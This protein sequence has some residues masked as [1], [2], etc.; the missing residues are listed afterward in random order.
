MKRTSLTMKIASAAVF[1]AVACY[2]AFSL[3]NALSDP[4]R[5]TLAV[6]M[7]AR[8]SFR[9]SGVIARSE[10]V[11]LSPGGA[12]N[13]LAGTGEKIAAGGAIAE[14][15][16]DASAL[17]LLREAEELEGRIAT[18]EGILASGGQP[19]K[20]SLERDIRE[21]VF[22][23]VLD[24]RSG[25]L[26]D[27]AGRL[28]SLEAKML[29]TTGGGDELREKLASLRQRRIAL[30]A[31]PGSLTKVLSPAS[32]VFCPVTDGY[33]DLTPAALKAM[34]AEALAQLI[35]GSRSAPS[36]AVGRVA[37][38]PRW[39]FATVL[40]YE[41]AAKLKSGGYAEMIFGKYL[42]T[43]IE[44]YV[45]SVGLVSG[46]KC[47]VV[48]SSNKNLADVLEARKQTVEIVY[49][50]YEG[51]RAPK[52][53]LHLDKD[54]KTCVF[55]VS[56]SVARLVEVSILYEADEYY[57]VESASDAYGLRAGDEI[58]TSGRDLYDGKIVG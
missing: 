30:G 50:S 5:T 49:A 13:V 29:S 15:C 58:I 31:L 8:E 3:I 47:A 32:G 24:V 36:G 17:S 7:A 52:K 54:G 35:G 1:L 42:G 14:I 22:S 56:G 20:L 43:G 27:V 16:S 51:V 34:T 44:M 25:S 57:I 53:A 12:V 38:G 2:M 33:E 28:H 18:L 11:V 48:F 46:G 37:S 6:S 10:T 9:A 41:D 40:S 4:L 26:G 23:L 19:D 39:Y 55:I 45:E 21:G